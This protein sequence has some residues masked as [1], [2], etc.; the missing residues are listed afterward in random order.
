MF[1]HFLDSM[2]HGRGVIPI[3]KAMVEGRRQVH[4][5]SHLYLAVENDRAFNSAVHA[6]NA[7]LRRVDDR[8]R[9]DTAQFAKTG[10]RDCRTR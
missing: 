3:D 2:N 4:H 1:E 8:R 9:G 6:D 5:Q 7:D 10:N